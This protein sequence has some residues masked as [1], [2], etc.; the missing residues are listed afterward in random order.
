MRFSIYKNYKKS[1]TK[2]ST[3]ANNNSFTKV[4]K[5]N[6]A[7]VE[8]YQ[9]N[10]RKSSCYATQSSSQGNDRSLE[11]LLVKLLYYKLRLNQ[12]YRKL[13]LNV[14]YRTNTTTTSAQFKRV[15]TTSATSVYKSLIKLV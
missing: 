6:N 5:I 14:L 7:A 4:Q 3:W 2:R 9:I 12:Q 10:L 1:G 8:G 13:L 15:N 11:S